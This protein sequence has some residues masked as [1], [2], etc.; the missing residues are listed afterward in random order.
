MDPLKT[1]IYLLQIDC[2]VDQITLAAEYNLRLD[3]KI[4][5]H[6]SKFI[7][8]NSPQLIISYL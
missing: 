1:N 8:D 7:K 5:H 4:H 6:L 2:M 3:I